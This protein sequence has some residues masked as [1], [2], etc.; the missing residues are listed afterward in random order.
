[1]LFP[2]SDSALAKLSEHDRTVIPKNAVEILA[3]LSH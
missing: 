1:M 2:A 3:G